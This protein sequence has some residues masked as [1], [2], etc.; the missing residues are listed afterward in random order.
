MLN[1]QMQQMN[2]SPLLLLQMKILK[3]DLSFPSLIHKNS[4][5]IKGQF[6]GKEMKNFSSLQSSVQV[7]S[8]T[9]SS[10]PFYYIPL[11]LTSIQLKM[12][13]TKL[14][15]RQRFTHGS[16]KYWVVMRMRKRG[17]KQCEW[18]KQKGKYTQQIY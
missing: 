1:L 5:K 18:C 16:N 2:S 11:I 12:V 7:I 9:R 3:N 17:S 8:P 10:F 15:H 13:S 14:D 6:Q 4:W